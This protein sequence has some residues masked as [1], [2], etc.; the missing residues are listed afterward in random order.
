[1]ICGISIDFQCTS[2]WCVHAGRHTTK[3]RSKK[4]R[5]DSSQPC[6]GRRTALVMTDCDKPVFLLQRAAISAHP[7]DMHSHI[8]IPL[9]CGRLEVSRYRRASH[10]HA[11]WWDHERS[12]QVF[13]ANK[14][15]ANR[16]RGYQ[17]P[18][19]RLNV[20]VTGPRV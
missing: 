8:P 7:W 16:W 4:S 10:G 20:T 19:P 3:K 2:L 9:E 14:M 15:V 12:W 5:P 13:F 18:H 1:M 17:S 11:M 6:Y